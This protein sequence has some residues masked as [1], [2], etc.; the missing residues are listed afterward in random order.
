M[1]CLIKYQFTISI[2][3]LFS[4]GGLLPH[5]RSCDDTFENSYFQIFKY[6]RVFE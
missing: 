5:F 1:Y 6:S 2:N 4:L 3:R